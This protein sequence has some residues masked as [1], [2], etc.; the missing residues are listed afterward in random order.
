L[1]IGGSALLE[2]DSSPTAASPSLVSM[3]ESLL[4]LAGAGDG[5]G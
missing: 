4:P 5:V 3:S 1:L 2:D